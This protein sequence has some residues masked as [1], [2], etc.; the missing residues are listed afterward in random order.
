MKI[1]KRPYPT[2]I[3]F[4]VVCFFLARVL[5][6]RNKCPKDTLRQSVDYKSTGTKGKAYFVD[7]LLAGL[8]TL[9]ALLIL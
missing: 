4:F 1:M 3:M 6:K 5:S 8:A 7:R 9:S 2:L